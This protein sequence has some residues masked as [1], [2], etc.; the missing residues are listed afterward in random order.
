MDA[1][2]AN[3]LDTTTSKQGS[4]VSSDAAYDRANCE[5]GDGECKA[6]RTADDIADRTDDRHGDGVD[7]EIRSAYPEGFS[8]RATNIAHDCLQKSRQMNMIG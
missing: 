2:T 4:Y 5:Y 6:N 8:G 3:T 7:E 1:T